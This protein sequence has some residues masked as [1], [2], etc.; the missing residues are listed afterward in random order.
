M[1]EALSGVG[2][3]FQRWNEDSEEWE[4]IAE[5]NSIE[6]PA[7]DREPIDVTS[8]DTQLGYDEFIS[9]F[10]EGND[11]LLSMNFTREGYELFCQDFDSDVSSYYKILIPDAD[12]E[13]DFELV[14][15]GLVIEIP[16]DIPVD[17]K[18]TSDV[19]IRVTGEVSM[20][21]SAYEPELLTYISGLVTPLSTGQLEALNTLILALKSGLSISA[22]SEAFDAMWLWAGETEESSLRNIVK[23]AHHSTLNNA[24]PFTQ[25]EG[26]YTNVSAVRTVLHNYNPTTDGVNYTL[27]NCSVGSYFRITTGLTQTLLSCSDGSNLT[28]ISD[29]AGGRSNRVYVNTS[30]YCSVPL[31]TP[32]VGFCVKGRYSNVGVCNYINKQYDEFIGDCAVVG[33]PNAD[34]LSQGDA[35]HA[36]AFFSRFFNETELGVIQD[37]IEA[38]MDAR[39]KGVIA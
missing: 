37:A 26:F 39:G 35:Q 36:C 27:N 2:T 21:P 10:K 12:E 30:G 28:V 11:V 24:P 20:E 17:N 23:N 15:Y 38:Y 34:S 18:I 31:A 32:G 25:Y 6:G 33:I 14:F 16:M 19:T 5:I 29:P 22:L 1:S 8:F 13:G 7:M 4:S 3:I 9:G